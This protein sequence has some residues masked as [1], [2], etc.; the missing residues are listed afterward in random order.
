MSSKKK[1][2]APPD[3]KINGLDEYRPPTAGT[4]LLPLEISKIKRMILRGLSDLEIAKELEK[5]KEAVKSV[6]SERCFKWVSP[7]IP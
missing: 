3:S 6:R 5:S 7:R 4:P 1:I 2:E